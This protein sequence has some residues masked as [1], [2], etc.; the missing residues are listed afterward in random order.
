MQIRDI[1]LYSHD[2]RT[3]VVPF[4]V[5]AVNVITGAS[6]SGKSALIDIVDYCFGADECGVP[7]GPIRRSV[8]WFGVRLQIDGGQAFIARRVP[9]P[10]AKASEECFLSFANDVS[11]PSPEELHQTTNKKGLVAE[12]SLRSGIRDNIHDPA[13]GQTRH[14]LSAVAERA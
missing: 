4:V 6:K 12:L 14:S 10:R 2:G 9:Q 1:V 8:S 11:I 7:E 3:R 13:P 5:G